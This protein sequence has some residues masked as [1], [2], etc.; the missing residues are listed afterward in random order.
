MNNL[1]YAFRTMADTDRNYILKSWN[2]TSRDSMEHI[3]A[4]TY[5]RQS[6]PLFNSILDRFGAIIA[7]N[8]DDP[9]QIYAFAVAAYL[10]E[11][12]WV[13]FWI[14]TKQIY[15]GLGI[16]KSLFNL[17]KGNRPKGPICPFV[18]PKSKPHILKYDGIEAPLMLGK[19]LEMPAIQ[20]VEI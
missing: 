15:E 1:R 2:R 8:P 11:D 7:C 17:I 16:G 3:D 19:I 18:R 6:N 13:M 10:P 9:D 20:Q 14:Q 5:Y 4:S 12:E